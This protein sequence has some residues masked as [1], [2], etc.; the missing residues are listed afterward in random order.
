[1]TVLVTGK[2]DLIRAINRLC[3]SSLC[4]MDGA[5]HPA[6][7]LR[8]SNLGWRYRFRILPPVRI[9]VTEKAGRLTAIQ[10]AA[11]RY[12]QYLE[13]ALHCH[14]FEWFHFHAF[15]EGT[16]DPCTPWRAGIG[17]LKCLVLL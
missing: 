11:Q 16:K 8:L 4:R 7:R 10:S 15:L 2:I 5:S 13:D 3:V 17:V 9:E 12:L 1:M 6:A 14:P